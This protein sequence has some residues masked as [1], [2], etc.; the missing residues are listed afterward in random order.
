M[1]SHPLLR[2]V[3]ASVPVTVLYALSWF[4]IFTFLNGYL[5]KELKYS[6]QEWTAV[7]LWYTGSMVVW[8]FVCSEL[9]SWIGRRWTVLFA[10]VLAGGLFLGFSF[11]HQRLLI[12]LML[13]CMALAVVI[14]STVFLPMVAEAGGEKPGR[15]LATFNLVNN[16][17]TASLLIGGG[18]LAARLGYAQAFLYCALACGVGAVLFFLFTRDF[19]GAKPAKVVSLRKLSR[20]DVLALLTGPFLIIVISGMSMEAFNY[21]TVNQLWPNLA[22]KEFDFSEPAIANMVALARLPALLTLSLV[23]YLID[24][25]NSVRFYGF[26]FL[27]VAI[28]VLALGL[29]PNSLGLNVAYVAYFLGMGFVWGSNSPAL[30]ASVSPRLRDSAFALMMVPAQ[31]AVF[32]VGIIHNRMLHAGLSLPEVFRWCGIIAALGGGLVLI[33]YSFTRRREPAPEAP[34]G[35]PVA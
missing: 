29:V 20:A 19:G 4:G 8:P 22:R 1:A 14:V 30:N 25:V 6:D 17:V 13:A 23:A 35:E 3:A 11:F 16:C 7:M 32:L 33:V 31:L 12:C 34:V 18:A 27:Y 21:H 5:V 28:C 15:A 26:S 10:L 2:I 24:R 9:S